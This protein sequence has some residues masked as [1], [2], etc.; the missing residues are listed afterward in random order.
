M[1]YVHL[2]ITNTI[3]VTCKH[4]YWRKKIRWNAL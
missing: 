1:P 2:L 4:Y 3:R